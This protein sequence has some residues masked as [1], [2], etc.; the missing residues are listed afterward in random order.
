MPAELATACWVSS[1]I[2]TTISLEDAVLTNNLME[3][4]CLVH[5]ETWRDQSEGLLL[6]AIDVLFELDLDNI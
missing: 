2:I 5:F 6:A 4:D 3:R 1:E